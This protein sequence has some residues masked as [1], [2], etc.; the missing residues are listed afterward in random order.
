SPVTV[1]D[2]VTPWPAGSSFDSVSGVNTCSSIN[3]TAGTLN[4]P[5]VVSNTG[6]ISPV[7]ITVKYP[8]GGVITNCATVTTA[9]DNNSANNQ[10]CVTNTVNA[11]PSIDIG[12]TKVGT[13][14]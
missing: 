5:P 14:S 6:V 9:G 13:V 7:I 8:A 1:S 10:S 4:C 2:V 12:V 3:S 11:A